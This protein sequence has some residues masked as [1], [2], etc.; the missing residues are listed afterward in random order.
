MTSG[1]S[2][3]GWAGLLAGRRTKYLVLVF[4]L[5]LVAVAGPFALKLTEVQDNDALGALPASGGV[6]QGAYAA[7]RRRSPTRRTA[8]G[9]RLRP[10]RS[11]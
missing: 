2:R 5:L 9:R 1:L 8:G 11:G 7:P 10:R 6:E 3:P 4:W